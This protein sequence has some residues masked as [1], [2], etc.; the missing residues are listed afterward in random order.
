MDAPGSI[1]SSIAVLR[2]IVSA[3]TENRFREQARVAVSEN[4]RPFRVRGFTGARPTNVHRAARPAAEGGL[5]KQAA[6]RVKN[7]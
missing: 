4:R 2:A 6:V 7:A 1:P 3:C 5:L